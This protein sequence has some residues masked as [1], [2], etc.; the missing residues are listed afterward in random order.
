MYYKKGRQFSPRK[1]IIRHQ[2]LRD[3]VILKYLKEEALAC[4]SWR[5]THILPVT[6]VFS[7]RMGSMG[8]TP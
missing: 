5:A 4:A 8:L 2:V 7:K 3:P 6:L 1:R